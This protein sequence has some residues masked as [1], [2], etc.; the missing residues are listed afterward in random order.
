MRG[1]GATPLWGNYLR[2]RGEYPTQMRYR[3]S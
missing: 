3:I 1:T 2:V